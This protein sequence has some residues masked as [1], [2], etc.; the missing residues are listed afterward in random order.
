MSKASEIAQDLVSRIR[1]VTRRQDGAINLSEPSFNDR[2]RALV[3]QCI[4]TA[5]VSTEG[6][7]VIKFEK[8]LEEI[9]G[10]P[11]VVATMNGT[12]AL[13]LALIAAGVKPGDEVITTPLTFVATANAIAHAGGV[14][15]FVDVEERTLGI[16]PEKLLP[17]L[18]EAFTSKDGKLIN[19]KTGRQAKVLLPMHVFGHPC[20][21]EELVTIARDFN[22]RVVED[23]AEALGSTFN[24]KH[25]GTFGDIGTLSFNGNKIVTTGGGG[26]ILFRNSNL[27]QK[28][29]HLSTTAK[30]PHAYKYFHDE[31]GYNYRLPN[32]NAALGVAQLEQL[33]ELLRKKR[34]L[35]QSYVNG[36]EDFSFG[37][38]FTTPD[39]KES[40]HWLNTLI[41]N[42]E[43]CEYRD[44]IISICHAE[45]VRLRPVWDLMTELPMFRDCP[46]ADI[47]TAKKISL[48]IINLPSSSFL[49]N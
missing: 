6:E 2:A 48:R 13:H 45:G 19:K 7:F 4:T 33:G 37:T 36:F 49:G 8:L 41:L 15:H 10:S 44:E 39:F 30:V 40:N 5:W 12:A 38:I 21:I 27:G 34:K 28:A 25:L 26:A 3:D 18:K 32:L 17:Y 20:K 47:S 35:A 43:F 14:P 22:L 46:S 31:I 11:K 23:A 42:P 24:G 16:C 29:K 9:T 1:S